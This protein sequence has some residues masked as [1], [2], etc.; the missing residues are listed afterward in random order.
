MCV[1]TCNLCYRTFRE[2]G[3]SFPPLAAYRQ[4]GAGR[5]DGAPPPMEAAPARYGAVH[6]RTARG[7][8]AREVKTEDDERAACR[9]ACREGRAEGGAQHLT[10]RTKLFCTKRSEF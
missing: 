9:A 6:P 3:S 4:H 1:E 10:P 5:Q 8:A 2:I 7:A